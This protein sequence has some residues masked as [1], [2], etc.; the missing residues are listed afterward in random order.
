MSDAIAFVPTMGALHAGHL[1][2]IKRARELSPTVVVSIFVNPLQFE[3]ADDLARYPRDID[4][5]TERALLAGAS[6]VWAPSYEEVYPTEIEKISAGSLGEIYEGRHRIGHFDGMLTVVNH[7]FEVVNPRYAI[8]GEKDFQQLFIVKKWVRENGIPVEIISAPTV[9]DSGGLALS[10]RN[11]RLSETERKSAL[12]INRA[13]STGNKEGMLSTLASESTF[14]L[15]YAE[16]IDEENFEIAT[17]STKSKRGIV[18]GW[19]NG[20][21][22]LDNMVMGSNR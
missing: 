9:R 2:L 8:F 6:R 11:S 20:V 22:L 13:L 21:R 1:E 16:I 7:L 17:P 4:G 18:A 3:N 19:I 10:S 5:D 14:Q 15:D 12:V